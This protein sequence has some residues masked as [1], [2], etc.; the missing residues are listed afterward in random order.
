MCECGCV[1]NCD[2]YFFPAP[3]G[4]MYLLTLS[5]HCTNCDAPTGITIELIEKD[6]PLYR[7]YKRGDFGTRELQFGDW[8][9]SEGVSVVCGFRKHEFIA[10]LIPHLVGLN[11]RNFTDDGK[12]GPL[13]ENAAEV[14]IDEM[15]DDAQLQPVLLGPDRED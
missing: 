3:K 6:N 11:S 15:Y 8:G 1:G 4:A 5:V 13:D 2:R 10:A 9:D 12:D 14:I 7:E